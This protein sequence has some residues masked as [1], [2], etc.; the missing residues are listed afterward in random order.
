MGVIQQIYWD[1]DCFLGIFNNES[2]KVAK[3]K[4]TIEQA[5]NGHLK[6]NTSA[7]TLTE[8]IKLKGKPRLSRDKEQMIIDFFKHECIIIH[9]VD[10]RTAEYARR[11]M[12][13]Y[14]SLK[15]KDSIHVATAV[16]R[17]IPTLHTF[18]QDLLALDS[19]LGTIK[20]R[21]CQSDIAYQM[22]LEQ[23][24]EEKKDE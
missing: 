21:I 1:S 17:K 15:P 23:L 9:N 16:I 22:E 18:D 20:L 7:L 4:G 10:R 13:R 6:I 3:C 24:Y 12:W 2:D 8:V 5:E 19:K 11:L 14:S